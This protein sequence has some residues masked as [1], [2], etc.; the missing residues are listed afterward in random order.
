M[1]IN[2][3]SGDI[4]SLPEAIQFTS[5]FREHYPEETKAFFVGSN[6]LNLVLAQ[7]NCIG[8]RIYNGYSPEEGQTNMIIV[9]VGIDGEDITTGILLEHLVPCP[10]F[11]AKNSPLT[12]I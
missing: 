6:K 11:C 2:N 8:V 3:N 7:Q 12:G 9:G 1:E 5:A 4:I 10:K